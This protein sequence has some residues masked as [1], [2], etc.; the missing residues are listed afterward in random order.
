MYKRLLDI[1]L[2][3]GL[4]QVTFH[5]FAHNP[6]E[7]GLPGYAYH[8]GE[9]FNVNSTWWN[10]AGPM[11]ADMARCCHL[12]Q[13]GRFIA[14]VCAYYGDE[15]PNLVP[16]RR[17]APTIKSQ[18]SD[19][20]CAH[21]GRPK[22]VDLDSLGHGYD[23][24]YINEEVILTR[25]KVQD[26]RLTLPDGMSYRVLVL[27]ARPAISPAVL[28]RIAELVE[29]GAT[30]VGPKPERSNSL[31][32][33]PDCDREVQDL[34]ARMWGDC[35]GDRVRRHGYGKGT[36]VWNEPL[37]DVLAG[38]GVA[39][40][41]VPE[42][43]GND[44]RHIDYIHRAT[45]DEDIYFV[46]NSGTNREVFRARFRAGA[47]RVPSLWNAEDGTVKPC[48]EYVTQDGFTR[49]PLDLSP[50]SSVFVVFA[51]GGKREHL[52]GIHRT[53]DSGVATPAG[54]L[55]DIEITG[56]EAGTVQA[57]VWRA[58]T[59]RLEA[60]GGRTGTLVAAHV[61]AD[62]AIDGPWRLSFP[63]GRGAPESVELPALLDWTRHADFGVQH[64]SGAATYHK[65]IDVPAAAAY[66]RDAVVLDLG[67]VK[68]L[69]VVR[70]NGREAGILWKAPY[71]I[72]IAAL[73]Q[74]GPNQLE[75]DVVNTWNNRLVGDR[76]SS[77]EARITRTNMSRSFNP[78]SPL[79]PSGLMGPVVL[80]F[81]VLATARLP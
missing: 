54:D 79:L 41:F 46:S 58:G 73:V 7:A 33:Y 32:G 6:P 59:Y 63:K 66:G 27:P 26:G 24:D 64:F 14:D 30:V 50:A 80:K 76:K 62:Q 8:A 1:A 19:D 12:L 28:N 20:C 74:P 23:Y 61:P 55:P 75:I 77:P 11:L 5:T 25:M 21:C 48:H 78:N 65:T 31:Q 38:M 60:A 57:R 34:A 16:A 22:P 43:V 67:R 69:A 13:Q 52:V 53:T 37:K 44:D 9:H 49:L 47:G 10:H 71:R 72:D 68:E 3:A 39:P 36:V 4:N 56:M 15:A 29:A 2:C 35:D 17:I 18:W 81:P 70:V 42:V 40:D 45:A 51:P